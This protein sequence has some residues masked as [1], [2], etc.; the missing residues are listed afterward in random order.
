MTETKVVSVSV[1]IEVD[2]V[3][4]NVVLVLMLVVVVVIVEMAVVLSRRSQRSR[5]DGCDSTRKRCLGDG[6]SHDIS[7]GSLAY[8]GTELLGPGIVG[9]R[10]QAHVEPFLARLVSEF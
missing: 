1:D 8:T 4:V 3:V 9:Q 2:V 7:E 5:G 6:C 10:G